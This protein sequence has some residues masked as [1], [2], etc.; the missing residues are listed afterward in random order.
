MADRAPEKTPE[1]TPE[2]TPADYGQQSGGE[3]QQYPRKDAK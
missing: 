2:R 3:Y 1:K